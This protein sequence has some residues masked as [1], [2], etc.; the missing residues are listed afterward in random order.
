MEENSIFFKI[1][2]LEQT[3]LKNLIQPIDDD[4]IKKI[5]HPPTPTQIKIIEYILRNRDKEEI[6]QKDVEEALKL[7]KATVSDVIGRMEKKGLIERKINPNDSRS[8]K[9]VLKEEAKKIFEKDRLRFEILEKKALKNI[10][11]EEMKNFLNV[12]DKITKNLD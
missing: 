5:N 3:I 4:K 11:D 2:D 10:T 8:K 1:K 12:I 9:I 7:S 6:Y